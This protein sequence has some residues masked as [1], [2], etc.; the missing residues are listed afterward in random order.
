MTRGVGEGVEDVGRAV[1][2]VV[3]GGDNETQ[4]PQENGATTQNGA[5]WHSKYALLLLPYLKNFPWRTIYAGSPGSFLLPGTS[6]PGLIRHFRFFLLQTASEFSALRAKNAG[7]L[8]APR[9]T[10]CIN[11]NPFQISAPVHKGREQKSTD[12]ISRLVFSNQR[13]DSADQIG[14]HLLGFP[15]ALFIGSLCRNIIPVIKHVNG[16]SP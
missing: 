13:A 8:I 16:I 7:H 12:R 1:D 10:L 9:C 15:Q 2:D 3:S 4:N 11:I 5:G 6:A 14:E